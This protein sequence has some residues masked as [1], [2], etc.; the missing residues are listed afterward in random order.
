M[1]AEETDE[2]EGG[3]KLTDKQ[4]YGGGAVNNKTEQYGYL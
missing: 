2:R 4:R 3:E 1:T